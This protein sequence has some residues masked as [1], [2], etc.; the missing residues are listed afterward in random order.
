MIS[1]KPYSGPRA[2]VFG[3]DVGTT[4]SGLS[5]SILEP[6]QTPVIRPITRFPGQ[7]DVGGDSKVP[8]SIFY[9]REGIIR[10]EGAE[11]MRPQCRDEAQDEGWELA[12][13]FKLHMRPAA[14]DFVLPPLPHRK[15]ATSVFADFL[16]YLFDCAKIYIE[17]TLGR[18]VWVSLQHNTRF[19]LAHPNG[20]EGKQQSQMRDAAVVAGLIPNS[21]AGHERLSFVTEGEASLHFCIQNGLAT[22][23][24]DSGKGVVVVDAG[25]GTIDLS[26]YR[27]VKKPNG[28]KEYEEIAAPQCLF[29]GSIYVTEHARR[30]LKAHLANS[31]FAEDV[32][33]ITAAFDASAK[34][35]FRGDEL[36]VQFGRR[37]D[38]DTR[39]NIRYGQLK[40]PGHVAKNFFE[41]SISAVAQ[42]V[43]D[44]CISACDVTG[45]SA[46][47][48]VGGFAASD[49]LFSELKSRL[50][51][52]MKPL[53]M[54]VDLTRPDAHLN[55]A[56]ADGAV[57]FYIDHHVSVR[58]A[59][60]T[61]GVQISE[62][63]DQ[64]KTEHITRYKSSFLGS[65]GQF[66][67]PYKFDPI[68]RK[69][70]Q[71]CE[72]T[73]FRSAYERQS[74]NRGDLDHFS[75]ALWTYRGLGDPRWMDIDPEHYRLACKIEADTSRLPK[76]PRQA[77]KRTYFEFTFEVVL[78]FGLTELKAEIAWMESGIERRGPAQIVY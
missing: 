47:F 34:L 39:L 70:I 22:Q 54:S 45:I 15:G 20:W 11:T 68:L 59:R 24:I 44:Q 66:L 32:D 33:A 18:D 51:Q 7:Q 17:E 29:H 78:S 9:D 36:S 49:W 67:I 58:V 16:R 76:Y 50:N 65:D 52:L 5:Y 30:Y 6:G 48:L 12:Q 21:D 61:Y 2:L 14:D 74:N 19:V 26:T 63:Y 60:F 27:V 25:G 57:S 10:A 4:F 46:V 35:T 73:E 1:R 13:W 75:T 64:K 8:T 41:P 3:I 69:D 55:K 23:A 42:A 62:P 72:K 71:V 28:G 56:V 43:M 53:K 31:K 37:T 38:N 77:G 40:I